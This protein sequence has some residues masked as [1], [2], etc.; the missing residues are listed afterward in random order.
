MTDSIYTI[1]LTAVGCTA[2]WQLIDHIL[3]ARRR[4]KF[5]I[6]EAVQKMQKDMQTVQDNQADMQK[7]LANLSASVAEDRAITSRV[8]I[9]SFADD[10]MSNKDH[11]KDAFDQVLCDIDNYDHY[12]SEHPRFKNNQTAMSR[13]IILDQYKECERDG[14]FLQYKRRNGR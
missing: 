2:F 10:M 3:E 1:V 9:L 14:T 7:S 8:R 12:C 11:S 5:D 6:E 13:E 4:K